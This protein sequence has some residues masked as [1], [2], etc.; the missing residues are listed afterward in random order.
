MVGYLV[1]PYTPSFSNRSIYLVAYI[2]CQRRWLC[3]GYWQYHQDKQCITA[4][5]ARSSNDD[6]E[7][8]QQQLLARSSI[9]VH[10]NSDDATDHES[11]L[12][13]LSVASRLPADLYPLILAFLADCADLHAAALVS[14]A[15]CRA[16]TPLLYETL[17]SRLIQT[18]RVSN[19]IFNE[20]HSFKFFYNCTVLIMCADLLILT[21][22]LH[23][24][25]DLIYYTGSCHT[26]SCTDPP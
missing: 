20:F 26:P 22:I 6:L 24:N 10:T 8:S 2:V 11:T 7:H 14:R 19:I 16:A 3:F 4:M 13:R 15:F 1:V 9:A 12:I 17:D 18:N 23:I 21:S 25:I 5:K